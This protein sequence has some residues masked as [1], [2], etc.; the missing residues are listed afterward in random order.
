MIKYRFLFQG[1]ATG[2]IPYTRHVSVT[3]FPTPPYR[4]H[5]RMTVAIAQNDRLAI[6][7]ALHVDDIARSSSSLVSRASNPVSWEQRLG[8]VAANSARAAAQSGIGSQTIEFMAAVGDD[9]LGR[10]LFTALSTCNVIPKLQTIPG[11]ATG[12]YTAI[13]NS[14]GELYIGLADVALA[15][16]L[17]SNHVQK[18]AQSG[19]Y[20]AF[21]VDA[22]LSEHCLVSVANLATKTS[23]RLAV[24][25]VSP[26]KSLRLRPIAAQVDLLFCNRREAMALVANDDA[27]AE[28]IGT[29]YVNTE[30][31]ADGLCKLG[32][33]QIVLTDAQEPILIQDS[34]S[35]HRIPVP[36]IESPYTVNGAGDAMAGACF[37]AWASGMSLYDSVKQHGINAATGVVR[38]ELLAIAL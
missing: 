22:N 3:L 9:S 30:L 28:L 11:H 19:P 32:F 15:E 17:A 25:T 29:E 37:A 5:N 20:S 34:D 7:G 8:G 26:S 2:A 36:N 23:T 13:L 6:I 10:S 38:G 4:S 18:L 33:K 1:V 12:R 31:L 16:Q 27:A 24:L 14:D 21:M 35:R